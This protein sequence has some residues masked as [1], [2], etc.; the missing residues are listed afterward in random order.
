MC[1]GPIIP[2]VFGLPLNKSVIIVGVIELVITI[3]ATI[4]NVLKYSQG[5]D[6]SECE[7]K[8][9]C[10]GPLIK[11]SVFDALFGVIRA[12]MLIVGGLQANVCLLISWLIIT[13]FISMK[14]LWVVI[15]HDW[16]NLEDWISITYLLYYLIVFLV[17]WSYWR[18]LKTRPI[19]HMPQPVGGPTVVLQQTFTAPPPQQ[20]PQ[21]SYAQVPAYQQQAPQYGQPPPYNPTYK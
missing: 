17:V 10:L 8:D 16:T 19:V 5:Y 14:Y 11:Y 9:V 15:T 12:L 21:Q 20:F 2:S 6:Q 1:G 3:I 13:P 4:L 18:E 7:G